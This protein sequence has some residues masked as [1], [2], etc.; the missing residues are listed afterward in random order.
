MKALRDL[1]KRTSIKTKGVLYM[2]LLIVAIY[3]S[4]S[5]VV[6]SSSRRN[7]N[8]QRQQFHKS[9]AEKLAINASDAIIS[10][11]YGFLMEQIRLLK[12]SG[13]AKAIKI[14]DKQGIIISSDTLEKIGKL[15]DALLKK[16][17]DA[18]SG[19][20]RNEGES[21]MFIPIGISGDILGGLEIDF[22]LDAEDAALNKEFK[23]TIIQL[24]YLSLIIFAVGIGGSFIVSMI[25]TRPITSLS[26]EIEA[27]EK[28][29]GLRHIKLYDPSDRDETVQLRHAFYNMI[30][31]LKRY[32]S[33]F[34]RMSEEREML[35]CM[36]TVGEMSAQIAHELRNSLH[37]IRGAI[38]GI[39]RSD[40]M[41]EM[42]E[43][44]AIIKD[45]TREMTMMADEFFRFAKMPSPSFVYCDAGDVI[46]RVIDLLEPDLEESNVKVI[47]KNED[48]V[49]G[50]M[51]DPTL[52]K[53]V[54]INLF[55]NAIQAMKRDGA[56]TV[57]YKASDEWLEIYVKDTG[58]GIPGE[59]AQKIFQPFFT[60]RADGTG[61]GLATVYKIILAHHG[62]IKLIPSERG[63]HFVIRLLAGDR[64]IAD[65][66]GLKLESLAMEGVDT[67][68]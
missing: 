54:F 9:V 10:E 12:S 35:T 3:V 50:I 11:D 38:S 32:L 63:A 48:G 34:R 26:K 7:L 42:R 47:K 44:I 27:F 67:K 59:I 55:M 23:K 57:E 45:E 5:I 31:D 43:Y 40:D 19:T 24:M 64:H 41:A 62:D 68:R 49:P 1:N 60:T 58:P 52:L 13:Q 8:I 20:F 66:G 29:I 39:E 4:V 46:N 16:L 17:E 18:G 22:D 65:T 37:S 25:M 53:Q 28:E 33:E 6:L 14:I 61:L 51:G 21:R 56:I 36:A 30:E 2:M 15:D